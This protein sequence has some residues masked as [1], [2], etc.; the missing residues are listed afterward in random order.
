[1][2]GCGGFVRAVIEV[3]ERDA[4]HARLLGRVAVPR[5]DSPTAG[6]AERLVG[7]VAGVTPNAR[8]ARTRS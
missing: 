1:V 5:D 8:H 4:S 7:V 2:R 3:V 6:L